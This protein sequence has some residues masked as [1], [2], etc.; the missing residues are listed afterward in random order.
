MG[1]T[2]ARLTR[3]EQDTHR[4]EVELA[5]RATSASRPELLK[6]VIEMSERVLAG[7][8]LEPADWTNARPEV[9][10]HRERLLECIRKQQD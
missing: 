9:V 2:A 3:A 5:R 7:E 10:A 6:R 8:E 4:R 1:K